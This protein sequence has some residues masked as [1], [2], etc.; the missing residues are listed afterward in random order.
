M[1]AATAA[2]AGQRGDKIRDPA[3]A[4]TEIL[5]PLGDA[6]RLVHGEERDVQPACQGAK[7]R[8]FEAFRRD[9]EQLIR[10]GAGAV[11]HAR[12][13][14]GGE[15]AVHER[16]RN[17][18]LGERRDLI[19]HQRD[20]RRN[21][22]RHARQQQGGDLIADALAATGRHNAHY[23]PPGE[24]GVDKRLLPGA[25]RAVAEKFFQ[26]SEFIQRQSFFPPHWN[27]CQ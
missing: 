25:E 17:A 6:V 15:R 21:D 22:E 9:V 26:N 1:K 20:E 10:P 8:H 24:R 19:R 16:R 14:R 2:T 11:E 3:V 23:V 18:A 12:L 4:R 5:P 13:L 27:F 7:L